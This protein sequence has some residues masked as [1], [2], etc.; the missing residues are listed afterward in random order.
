MRQPEVGVQRVTFTSQDD[1]RALDLAV[2]VDASHPHE[3]YQERFWTLSGPESRH[4]TGSVD[5]ESTHRRRHLFVRWVAQ[6]DLPG[7][8]EELVEEAWYGRQYKLELPA[9]RSLTIERTFVVSETDTPITGPAPTFDQSLSD[10]RQWWDSVWN[11]ADIEIEGDLEAQQGI[12]FS[13]FQLQQTCGSGTTSFVGAKGMTGEAYNGH[14]FWDTEIYCLPHFLFSNPEA[15][16]SLLAFRAG[17]LPQAMARAKELDCEGA[18]FPVATIDGTESCAL[19]Q[20]ANLQ[21][22]PT[23]AVTYAVLHYARVTADTRFLVDSGIELLVQACRFL[24]SRGQWSGRGRR[25]GYYGVMGPDEFHMIVNNNAYTNVMARFTF[26]STIRAI[27]DASAAWPVECAALLERL[28]CDVR[29]RADWDEKARAMI[30]PVDERTGVIEQHE[31]YFDLPHI[32]ISA[33]PDN[34][35]PLYAHWSYDR[36][37]RYDM[38]KQPD[39]LMFLFLLGEE[40][41]ATQKIANYD[42]YAPRCIH[43]SSLSP[44]I[45]SI[46]AAELG[47]QEEARSLF[48]FATRIDL[49][50]YNR[51]TA[52]G[53]HMTSLAAAWM[54][55]V[56]GFG[57]LRSD[58]AVLSLDPALPETWTACR[59]R[60]L[61]R[62]ATI[63]VAMNRGATTVRLVAGPPVTV[64]VRGE[65][66]L[67]TAQGVTA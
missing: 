44:S 18:C 15:A 30:V 67:L 65:E 52:E 13:I 35:F 37:F 61:Y 51:N 4:A 2:G 24:A 41:P 58:G 17:T 9:G 34:E 62:G 59:F 45:H 25:F 11:A 21:L 27:Q 53:L 26:L 14:T 43:E 8:S 36:I 29:E 47:R 64:R 32:D 6:G 66:R 22:Q 33:I 10:N 40:F 42:Y 19:W 20:H 3:S 57:G 7:D 46:L 28:S 49:D 48:R 31:G 63:E 56:Y 23:T 54:N 38:I 5:L 16:K 55:I 50:N 12:R 39:V 1:P 60:M